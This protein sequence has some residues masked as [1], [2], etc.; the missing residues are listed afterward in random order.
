M[1]DV[2]KTAGS[3]WFAI[4][5]VSPFIKSL[6]KGRGM[7]RQMIRRSKFKEVL[8]RDLESRKMGVSKLPME[9]HIHDIIGADIVERLVAID[10]SMNY[11]INY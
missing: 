11:C 5:G 9:Y 8:R 7:I 6:T 10:Q 1:R 4:P 3:W 2:G